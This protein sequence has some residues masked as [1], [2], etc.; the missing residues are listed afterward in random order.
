MVY[1]LTGDIQTGKS[2][3]LNEWIKNKSNVVGLLSLSNDDRTRDFVDIRN[4]Q[5]FSMH[6][7]VKSPE[8]NKI[9]VGKFIFSKSAF[10]RANSIIQFEIQQKDYTYFIVDELGK[11]ELKQNG[12]YESTRNLARKF[13]SK[14]HTHLILVVRSALLEDIIEHYNLLP[15]KIL[16]K[17]DLKHL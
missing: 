14:K 8:E 5:N 17:K 6:T 7:S 1:I 16:D 10:E 13:K 4:L 15:N 11:L 9:Y 12:L 3:A 2:Y